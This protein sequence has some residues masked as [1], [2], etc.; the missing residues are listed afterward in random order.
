MRARSLFSIIALGLGNL[1]VG[2]S[3]L[4][5]TAMLAELSSGLAVSIGKAGLLTSL[6][7]AV[8]CVSPPLVAWAT[9]RVARR[10]LLSAILLCLALGHVASAFVPDFASLLLI[11]L[12][13]LAVAGAFTPLAAET[14]ALI[15][16]PE[17]RSSAVA[18]VLLG[19]AL[20]LA[21]GLP[22]VAATVPVIGWRASYELVG[23]L[24]AAGFL[25]LIFGLRPGLI[26][27]PVVFA[28]WFAV[29]RNRTLLLL[30]SIT[31]L[32]GAGQLVIV[33][34]VGPLLTQLAGAKSGQIAVVFA[35]FGVTNVIGN[36]C[37]A[38]LVQSWGALK[39]SI[40]FMI[41]VL[42]GL[43]IWTFGSGLFWA[44]ATG[45][46]IWG[47]GSAAVAAM[48]QVRLIATAPRLATASVA[49]NNTVLY[50]GQAIGAGI[51]GALFARDQ[52]TAI[53][54]AALIMVALAFALVWFTR[55]TPN[56]DGTRFDHETIQLL[57][58]AFDRAWERYSEGAAMEEDTTSRHAELAKFIVAIAQAGE[59]DEDRLSLKG[60]LKLRAIYSVPRRSSDSA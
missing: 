38:R 44:M 39:T 51:G 27:T 45:A 19:W 6:G 15:V 5:P 50:L 58:R 11:R 2:L 10:A 34:F 47:F 54:F 55:A 14:A 25:A 20:A 4:L 43:A 26:G 60:Y 18:S 35:L 21:V 42:A 23:A 24:A 8:V 53:G 16:P 57:A 32:L 28:T 48:Q 3:I 1:V 46:A 59:R 17:N 29:G 22:T 37:A 52:P 36:V 13:M 49:L 9:S 30:L 12:A 7:A 31:G 40:A 33:A 56:L 41:C